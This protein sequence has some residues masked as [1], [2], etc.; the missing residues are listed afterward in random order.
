MEMRDLGR[1]V[2][3]GEMDRVAGMR[4]ANRRLARLGVETVDLSY[5]EHGCNAECRV[6]VGRVMQTVSVHGASDPVLAVDRLVA[7]VEQLR[8]SRR[9]G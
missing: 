2:I 1:A 8:R 4:A 5:C 6:Q 7:Q 9:R 3:E